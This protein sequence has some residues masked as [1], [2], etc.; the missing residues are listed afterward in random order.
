MVWSHK[1]TTKMFVVL[2]L[3]VRLWKA[4]S[5][6]TNLCFSATNNRNLTK[7]ER[8]LTIMNNTQNL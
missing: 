8:V 7:I 4:Q 1:E 5:L 3:Y 2:K 6:N